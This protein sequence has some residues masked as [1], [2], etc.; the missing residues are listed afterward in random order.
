MKQILKDLNIDPKQ[1]DPRAMIA[2]IS[3]MKN[4]LIT[5][6]VAL[7]RAGK[8]YERQVAEIYRCLSKDVKEKPSA[9]F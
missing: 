9:R 7:E 6:E 3:N 5:P 1:Y 2:Q 8:F 4:E